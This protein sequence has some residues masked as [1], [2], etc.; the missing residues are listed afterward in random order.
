MIE[1]GAEL[2]AGIR[3]P[4]VVFRGLIAQANMTT[5]EFADL[6]DSRGLPAAIR[7]AVGQVEQ[8]NRGRHLVEARRRLVGYYESTP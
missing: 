7:I 2:A 4:P 6:A 8:R 5:K 1:Y 3:T